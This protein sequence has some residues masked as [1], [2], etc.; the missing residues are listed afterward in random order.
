VDSF[1]ATNIGYGSATGV[2]AAFMIGNADSLFNT[3][4]SAFA[5]L[6]GTAPVGSGFDWGLPFFFG[7]TIYVGLDGTKSNLATGPYWAY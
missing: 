1:S 6:G 5:E 4:N 7:K 3:S 2:L